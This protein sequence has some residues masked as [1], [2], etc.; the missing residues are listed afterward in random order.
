ML[1]NNKTLIQYY[2]IIIYEISTTRL[3][4]STTTLELN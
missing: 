3:T 4:T 1:Q 2:K